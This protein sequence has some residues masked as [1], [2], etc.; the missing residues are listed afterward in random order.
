MPQCLNEIGAPV[1]RIW[2]YPKQVLTPRDYKF[3][4]LLLEPE[5]ITARGIL[6]DFFYSAREILKFFFISFL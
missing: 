1:N 6:A 3:L 5:I 2:R 4:T